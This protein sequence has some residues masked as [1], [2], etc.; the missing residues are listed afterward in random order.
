MHSGPVNDT[1]Q[2]HTKEAKFKHTTELLSYLFHIRFEETRQDPANKQK[3]LFDKLEETVVARGK[4]FAI[5]N[6]RNQ[7]YYI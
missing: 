3:A 2:T 5:M 4:I 6:L 7:Q 1:G